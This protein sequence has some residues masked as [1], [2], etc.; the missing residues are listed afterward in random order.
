MVGRKDRFVCVE[1]KTHKRWWGGRTG[2]CGEGEG[3]S[4][5]GGRLPFHMISESSTD[6]GYVVSKFWRGKIMRAK[7]ERECDVLEKDI[8]QARGE[9]RPL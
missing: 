2:S 9:T 8:A 3:W 1:E 7:E 4:V 5:V 6:V